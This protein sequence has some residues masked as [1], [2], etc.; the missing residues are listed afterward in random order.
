MKVI[1]TENQLKAID[2]YI[3]NE[4]EV[5]KFDLG[6]Y[7]DALQ[8]YQPIFTDSD[9]NNVSD[10]I[11]Y[12]PSDINIPTNLTFSGKASDL[13]HPLGKKVRITS[14]FG[15]RNLGYGSKNHKGVD[16]ATPSGSPIYTPA[17]GIVIEA[18]STN[19]GCGGLIKINHGNLITKY[20]HVKQWI[21]KKGEQVKKGQQIGYSGGGRNDPNKGTSSG[22]HL[23]YEIIDTNSMAAIDPLKVQNNLA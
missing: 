16:L 15:Y 12:K 2:K 6:K 14:K 19:N 20:C 22:P 17:N 8:K 18:T 9:E 13:L 4:E 21:V 3:L 7:I 11:D 5:S 23:H 10:E 1:I